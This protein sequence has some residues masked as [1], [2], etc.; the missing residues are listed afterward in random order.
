TAVKMYRPASFATVARSACVAVSTSCTSAP[1]TT[2]P[3]GS[4]TTPSTVP[5]LAVCANAAPLSVR[6]RSRNADVFIGA[7]RIGTDSTSTP[8]ALG[9]S[10]DT[11]PPMRIP[12]LAVLVLVTRALFPAS[13]TVRVEVRERGT[14]RA[15]PARLYLNDENGKPF[16][17]PGAIVYE[18]R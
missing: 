1:G 18:K 16:A 4:F 15:I 3:V 10:G 7:L 5:V 12:L 13:G 6:A 8:A 14:G 2:A 17:P 11:M 9:S